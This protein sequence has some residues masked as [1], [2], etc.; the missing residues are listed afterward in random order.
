MYGFV[1]KATLW[2][3]DTLLFQEGGKVQSNPKP[4]WKENFY[5]DDPHDRRCIERGIS[6]YNKYGIKVYDKQFTD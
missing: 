3:W 5:G 6:L 1:G 2:A 4:E